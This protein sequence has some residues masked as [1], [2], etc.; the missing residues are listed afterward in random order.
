MF[1]QTEDDEQGS[2]QKIS[3]FPLASNQDTFVVEIGSFGSPFMGREV[4]NKRVAQE[5]LRNAKKFTI[6]LLVNSPSINAYGHLIYDVMDILSDAGIAAADKIITPILA[7]KA[8]E[9]ETKLM[10]SK[11]DKFKNLK[12]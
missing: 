4:A 5:L 2:A 6:V 12:V 10:E 9:A 8:H 7:S 11:P 1:F 3:Y